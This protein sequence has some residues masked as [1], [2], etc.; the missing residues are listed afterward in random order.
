LVEEVL[1]T[2]D[3]GRLPQQQA[4]SQERCETHALCR[5]IV[6]VDDGAARLKVVAA[7]IWYPGTDVCHGWYA[8]VQSG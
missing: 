5:G 7:E 2:G 6:K 3:D 1:R 4:F 8:Q